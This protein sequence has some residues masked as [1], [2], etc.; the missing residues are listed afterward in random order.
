M[1]VCIYI[2]VIGGV[3]SMRVLLAVMTV[4]KVGIWVDLQGL[5]VYNIG[6]SIA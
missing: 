5:R 4:C 1:G 3:L 6:L 2:G